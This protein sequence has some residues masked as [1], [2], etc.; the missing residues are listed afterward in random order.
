[1]KEAKATPGAWVP[2]VISRAEAAEAA[3][4]E[5]PERRPLLSVIVPAFN[6]R[7]V[8]AS[9]IAAIKLRLRDLDIDHEIIVVCDGSSDGTP[10][11]VESLLGDDPSLRLLSYQQ[12][13]G[14]GYA[15]R[16]GVALA[17]GEY[18]MF[19]DADLAIPV[20]I[21]E[22]FLR[23]L[24]E[25]YD[26]AIASRRHP[27]STAPMPPPL[28]RRVMG[29]A[30]SWCVRRIVVSD[31]RDTQCGCKA[32][33]HEVAQRLF[34]AQQIDHFS[35]DAEVIFLAERAGYRIK[36]VPFALSHAP[37]GSSIRPVRDSLKMVRDLL[38]IR[39]NAARG[40]YD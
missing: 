19:T 38:R 12:N 30:F 7:L 9:S 16:S 13:R 34:A 1:V 20:D 6:E 35:F 21:V 3:T 32:Y 31:V 24:N 8:I 39:L 18:V 25:G 37:S 11:I 22:D 28:L 29:E 17:R 14:K 26:I 36:E 33:R 15:V 5:H 10:Q 23:V 4:L 40:Q 2:R 27:Q